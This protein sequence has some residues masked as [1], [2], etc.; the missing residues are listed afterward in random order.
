M[1]HHARCEGQPVTGGEPG[2]SVCV[3]VGVT[4]VVM[5]VGGI[6]IVVGGAEIVVGGT[7]TVVIIGS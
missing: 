6:V 4:I 2:D 1:H 7:V 3:G 5:V